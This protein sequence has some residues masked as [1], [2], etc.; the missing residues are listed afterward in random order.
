MGRFVLD[1]YC[2]EARLAIEA[3]G[4]QHQATDRLQ[5]DSMRSEQLA[6]VHVRVLRFQ[7]HD[8]FYDLDRVCDEIR[9]TLCSPLPPLWERGRG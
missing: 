5:Y 8:V 7:N 2:A 4:V 1:F 6:R 9:E 3:D